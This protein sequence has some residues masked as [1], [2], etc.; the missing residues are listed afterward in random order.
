MGNAPIQLG[1]QTDKSVYQHGETLTGTVYLSVTQWDAS[2]ANYKGIGLSFSGHEN[3]QVRTREE[4]GT[5]KHKSHSY[6]TERESTTIVHVQVPLVVKFASPLRVAKYE[7]PFCWALPQTPLPS[8][9]RHKDHTGGVTNR[10]GH[11]ELRYEVSAYLTTANDQH[12][13]QSSGLASAVGSFFASTTTLNPRKSD[14]TFCSQTIQFVGAPT[15][16]I[17]EPLQ[18]A[19]ERTTMNGLCCCWRQGQVALGWSADSIVL[20]PQATCHLY[21][22]GGNFSSVHV[23]K[24]RVQLMQTVHWEAG[25][26]TCSHSTSL[27]D[28]YVDVSHLKQWDSIDNKNNKSASNN[29]NINSNAYQTVQTDTGD[30]MA[31]PPSDGNHN[32]NNH[33]DAINEDD[34]YYDENDPEQNIEPI[35]TSFQVPPDV[36]DSYRGH[37]CRVEHT[38]TISCVTRLFSTTPTVPYQVHL[39]RLGVGQS[40][41]ALPIATAWMEESDYQDVELPADWAPDEKV[42]VIHLKEITTLND[43]D[44]D[45]EDDGISNSFVATAEAVML[46]PT[47]AAASAAVTDNDDEDPMAFARPAGMDPSDLKYSDNVSHPYTTT[48]TA[49]PTVV[50]RLLSSLLQQLRQRFW[51]LLLLVVAAGQGQVVT[52]TAI[53]HR[54]RGT[55][56]KRG[57]VDT[58]LPFRVGELQPLSPPLFDSQTHHHPSE[59]NTLAQNRTTASATTIHAAAQ[60]RLPWAVTALLDEYCQTRGILEFLQRQLQDDDEE[61]KKTIFKTSDG[62]FFLTPPETTTTSPSTNAHYLAPA[63]QEAQEWLQAFLAR[64]EFDTV[65]DALGKHFDVDELQIISFDFVAATY[66]IHVK[67]NRTTITPGN[68]QSEQEER[69]HPGEAVHDTNE[70]SGID[71][72][73]GESQLFQLLIPLYLRE[74]APPE[75]Q[76]E[77][78]QL[79]DEQS[80]SMSTMHIYHELDVAVVIQAP[81]YGEAK[82][83]LGLSTFDYRQ[84]K[85][86]HD[87]DNDSDNDS[88]DEVYMAL[89]I[90]V[91]ASRNNRQENKQQRQPHFEPLLNALNSMSISPPMT[92]IRKD[93]LYNQFIGNSSPH[94]TKDG[95]VRLL[96]IE[97]QRYKEQQQQKRRLQPHQSNQQCTMSAT[98]E[99]SNDAQV[100][101]DKTQEEADDSDEKVDTFEDD[102][103][104]W[105]KTLD[106]SAWEF[107]GFG[108][109]LACNQYF[110][111]S[112]E[113]TTPDLRFWKNLRKTYTSIVGAN[114]STLSLP[115]SSDE[116]GFQVDVKAMVIPGKGRGVVANQFIPKGTLVYRSLQQARFSSADAYSYKKL[117]MS[118]PIEAACDLLAWISIQT[119]LV[120]GEEPQIIIEMDRGAL[121][122]GGTEIEENM[123]EKQIAYLVEEEGVANLGCNPDAAKEL[124]GG[125]RLNDFALSDIQIGAEL[126]SDYEGFSIYDKDVWESFGLGY[127]DQDADDTED[128]DDD[129]D[130]DDDDEN[131]SEDTEDTEE[132][133]DSDETEDNDGDDNDDVSDSEDVEEE[134]HSDET[135]NDEDEVD[136][137]ESGDGDD[138]SQDDGD[139]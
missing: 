136:D 37:H 49:L 42:P 38:L 56:E 31:P 80:S 9:F 105:W 10:T 7:F 35:P 118:V 60:I 97:D 41:A 50:A 106:W 70:N 134:N 129:D 128:N 127:P 117:I 45:D 15:R 77:M 32:H 13:Q 131:D 87:S 84:G 39:Q 12:Q 104:V 116:D 119:L 3:T 64:T 28:Y 21:I 81:L 23:P 101:E 133:I 90:S 71:S 89:S 135:D 103:D 130:D 8:S 2:L 124:P 120:D 54:F 93:L 73:S 65:L 102:K 79:N 63:N 94:W 61:E 138:N 121:V 55:Q 43:D 29:N 108:S 59:N 68:E 126:L 33:I 96:T 139:D 52:A 22:T 91:L 40:A 107:Q 113:R 47:A 26:D 95:T 51:P 82:N 86:D 85:V 24:L 4:T 6:R 20:T 5:G 109:H 74:G 92:D 58:V 123:T 36:M 115:L 53:T 17:P 72:T 98:H 66:N 132:E 19:D 76:L 16:Y 1:I 67:K 112:I 110:D 34:D 30:A 122:N 88:L 111:E 27:V 125:C 75:L 100:C 18:L 114:H 25:N 78:A 46:P 69:G 57:G 14:G 44:E 99:G 83:H 137:N 11:C 62:E 48:A